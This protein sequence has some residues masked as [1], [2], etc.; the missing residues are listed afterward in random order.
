MLG[1]SFTRSPSFTRVSSATLAGLM[2]IIG[3]G[4][5]A[6]AQDAQVELL[7]PKARQGYYVGGGPRAL[8]LVV[9]DE[10]IGSLGG[11]LGFG[12]A[13]RF[14]QKVNEWL[15]LGLVLSG[16]GAGNTDW[17]VGGG[18]L[19]LEAQ[20][21]PWLDTNLAFRLG[22]GVAGFAVSRVESAEETDDDPEGTVG[23][24][25]TLGASYEVYP[26][27][28]PGAY[29][30]GGLAFSFFVEGQFSPG[31]G[32]VTSVGAVLG[33]EFT[34]WSGL[35]RNKLDLPVDAAFTK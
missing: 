16:G 17:S 13:F 8:S 21:Q 22:I 23:S 28:E 29:D 31:L 34:W 11:M 19:T 33:V 30:S 14:G 35:S 20:V 6:A 3:S 12:F 4:A 18:G 24:I 2:V 32:G 26:W 9:D 7:A 1:P 15:G 27:Y 5:T 25:Y 10:D